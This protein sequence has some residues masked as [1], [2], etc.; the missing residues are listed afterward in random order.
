[1]KFLI[2]LLLAWSILLAGDFT[3]NSPD[4][5]GQLSKKQEFNGYGCDGKNISPLLKWANPPKKTKSFA[6]TIY[7]P[8][9]PTGSGW[10]HWIVYNIPKGIRQIKSGASKLKLLPKGSVEGLNDYKTK[11]FG[12]ACPP[13]ED[14]A[15]RYI[16]TIYA[17][18]IAKL[19]IDKNANPAL[20]G[21]ILNS[22]SIQ[23]SS[24][25]GYFGR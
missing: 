16:T 22:H 11:N 24:I 4:M 9:A 13:K 5:S 20:I 15:H 17:L 10:W 25:V 19:N 2:N 18:D 8:D 7:D 1:M 14:K 12:G 6:I 3:L 21:Y 23:K